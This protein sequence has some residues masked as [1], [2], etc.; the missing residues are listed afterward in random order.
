M[1]SSYAVCMTAKVNRSGTVVFS[2]V[3]TLALTT[4]FANVFAEYNVDDKYQLESVFVASGPN[5]LWQNVNDTE[6]IIL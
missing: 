1:A 4:N 6:C 2:R 3:A 5:G